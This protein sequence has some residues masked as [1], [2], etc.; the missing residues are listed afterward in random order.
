MKGN[1]ES[2]SV[3]LSYK[4]R[5][6]RRCATFALKGDSANQSLLSNEGFRLRDTTRCAR[7]PLIYGLFDRAAVRSRGG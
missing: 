5:A 2:T 1:N 6:F 4:T 3:Y 7:V